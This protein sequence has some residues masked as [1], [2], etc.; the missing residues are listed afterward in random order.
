MLIVLSATGLSEL[1]TTQCLYN[2]QRYC[3]YSL[4]PV[5]KQQKARQMSAVKMVHVLH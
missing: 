2:M 5:Q 1:H 3:Y 4:Y